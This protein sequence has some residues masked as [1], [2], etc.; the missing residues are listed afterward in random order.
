MSVDPIA[1]LGAG[2]WGTALALEWLRSGHAVRLWARRPDHAATIR[3]GSNPRYLPGVQIPSNLEVDAR[4]EEVVTG[5]GLVVLAVPAAAVGETCRALGGH[6]GA[7]GVPPVVCAAKG[8]ERDTGRRM[9]QV[10]V[11]TLGPAAERATVLLGP[12]HAEEVALGLPTAIVLAGADAALRAV[13]QKGLASP[14][15]RIYTNDDLIGV[16][17]AA[18]L[19]NVLAIAAGICDGLEMGDNI[20]G[21]LLTR[22]LTEISRL[23]V[24]MGGRRETFFGLSGVG[25]V[26]TTCLSRHSRNRAL[27]ESVGRGSSLQ[28]A[29]DRVDQVVEGVATTQTITALAARHDVTMPISHQVGLVLFEGKSPRRAIDDLMMRDLKSEH[30]ADPTPEI[31]SR[32]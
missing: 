15:F 27:G 22:G 31:E 32:R 17:S 26:I 13:L 20:K 23:G 16:E 10:M 24:A 6:L 29:L 12:S 9:S 19:K 21:A 4:L 30:E 3:S 25:D 7:S 14:G 11:A 8:L 5:A 2:S 18:A 28:E 1:V